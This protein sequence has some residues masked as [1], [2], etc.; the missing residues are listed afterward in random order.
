MKQAIVEN[1]K[2]NKTIKFERKYL[3]KKNYKLPNGNPFDFI[4]YLERQREGENEVNLCLFLELAKEG[5][6]VYNH[7]PVN[8]LI[9]DM[10][11]LRNG[12]STNGIFIIN[13]K[14]ELETNRF[15][16]INRPTVNPMISKDSTELPVKI[17]S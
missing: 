17:R 9:E 13:G 15:F 10:V 7:A 11:Y 4:E 1:E 8:T 6:M 14:G 16:R 5:K 12:F 3:S 2:L